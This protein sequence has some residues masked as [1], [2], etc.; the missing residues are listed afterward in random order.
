[1]SANEL[2]DGLC[3]E[4]AEAVRALLR[5]AYDHGFREGLASLGQPASAAAPEP[6]TQPAAPIESPPS[7]E[8]ELTPARAEPVEARAVEGTA[9]EPASRSVSWTGEADVPEAEPAA[10]EDD[11]AN[12]G[13]VVRPILPLAT[14]GTL[15]RRIIRTFDLER[16]DIDV[17]IC[18]TGDS[19]RRQL[20]SSVR[21]SA[22][23]KE[24]A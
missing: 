4:A 19:D 10:E 24:E 20:K 18:R 21:L 16:F 13:V 14:V 9:A 7:P 3:A 8:P 17:V 22:Y 15:R 12:E 6:S 11:D 2:I 1:M 5:R 23:R